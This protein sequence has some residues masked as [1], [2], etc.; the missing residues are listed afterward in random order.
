[1]VRFAWSS[2]LWVLVLLRG[3]LRGYHWIRCKKGE[4]AEKR[5]RRQR[6]FWEAAPGG[7][8]RQQKVAPR[9]MQLEGVTL[10]DITGIR[11]E[12]PCWKRHELILDACGRRSGP[13]N[14]I[15]NAPSLTGQL[16]VVTRLAPGPRLWRLA[17]DCLTTVFAWKE[18]LVPAVSRLPLIDDAS[19]KSAHVSSADSR[20]GWL[21]TN[22]TG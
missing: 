3:Y 12:G 9:H 2:W 10:S 5:E 15:V 18:S 7:F 16:A 17:M 1:M 21:P 11:R 20:H 14:L 22:V 6:C 4:W 19:N 13:P 8:T